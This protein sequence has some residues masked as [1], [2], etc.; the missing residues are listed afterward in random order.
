MQNRATWWSAPARMCAGLVLVC[1]LL[2]TGCDDDDDFDHVPA[3]GMGALVIDNDTFDDLDIFVDGAQIGHVT[4]GHDGFFD[5]A[6]GL[7]RIVLTD[8]DGDRSYRNEL[9]VLVGRLTVMYVDEPL[10]AFADEYRVVVA[11]D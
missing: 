11:Y 1:C 2:G 5:M 3:E 8:E 4:D 6:P 7:Y 9:D 10:S